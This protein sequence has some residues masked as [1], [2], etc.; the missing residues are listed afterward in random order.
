[1]RQ[2]ILWSICPATFL[3]V[4]SPLSG[5]APSPSPQLWQPFY[6]C[7]GSSQRLQ[8][9]PL[10][11]FPGVA[12]LQVSLLPKREEETGRGEGDRDRQTALERLAGY[13][14]GVEGSK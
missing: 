2:E 9:S 8:S 11:R 14:G 12:R 6:D 13:R 7:S 3:T 4:L 10:P 1:M 5:S